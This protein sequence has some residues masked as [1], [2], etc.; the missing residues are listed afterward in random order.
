VERPQHDRGTARRLLSSGGVLYRYA[1][2]G[3]LEFLLVGRRQPALWALP[4]GTPVEGES[5]QQTAVRE[6]EEETGVSG[7][8]VADLGTISYTFRTPPRG[9]ALPARR[10][11]VD[12]Q[13]N[14]RFHKTVHHFLLRPV[15]GD[16]ALHDAEYDF[17]RWLPAAEALQL[18]SHEN[19]RTVLRRALALLGHGRE[20]VAG[21][22]R[23]GQPA[24]PS[25]RPPRRRRRRA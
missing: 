3:V 24:R 14:T 22:T 20:R 7:E 1:Y 17:A 5:I 8:I 13:P 15:A 21:A 9:I 12:A 10:K 18:V 4:K 23:A 6:V 11:D 19:E 2:D 25:G 16:P